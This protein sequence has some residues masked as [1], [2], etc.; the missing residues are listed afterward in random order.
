MLEDSK[1]HILW[2]AC[3]GVCAHVC[4]N[5]LVNERHMYDKTFKMYSLVFMTNTVLMQVSYW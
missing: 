3:V 4:A 5:S 1:L 2:C